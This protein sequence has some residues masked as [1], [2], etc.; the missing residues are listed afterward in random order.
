MYKRNRYLQG[1]L[2]LLGH[3]LRH[4]MRDNFFARNS[5]LMARFS[6]P[7][8]LQHL[9]FLQSHELVVI[10]L[11]LFALHRLLPFCLWFLENFLSKVFRGDLDALRDVMM[12]FV[13][14]FL[15][16]CVLSLRLV[17]G[18]SVIIPS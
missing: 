7:T 8:L 3:S 4:R 14:N 15:E 6:Q 16:L 12:S 18:Q 2:I 5:K 17:L 9:F 1:F 10:I 11:V 13:E